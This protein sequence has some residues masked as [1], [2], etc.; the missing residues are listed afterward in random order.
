MA[1]HSAYS[2]FSLCSV[3]VPALVASLVFPISVFR[4][5][6]LFWLRSLFARAECLKLHVPLGVSMYICI[7]LS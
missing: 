4:V 1:A 5:E 6:L 7:I 2:M 3:L